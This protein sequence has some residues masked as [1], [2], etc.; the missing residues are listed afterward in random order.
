MVLDVSDS[1]GRAVAFDDVV[2]LEPAAAVRGLVALGW[3]RQASTPP[4]DSIEAM[5]IAVAA[6]RARA[7][8]GLRRGRGMGVGSSMGVTVRT[9]GERPARV[10]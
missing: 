9:T 1:D 3:S 4:S 7:A 5:L 6:L 8:R 10:R 2:E